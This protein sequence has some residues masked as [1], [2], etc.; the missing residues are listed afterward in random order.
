[1][2]LFTSA[3][4]AGNGNMVAG[5]GVLAAN[6][7][8]SMGETVSLAASGDLTAIGQVA[9][10]VGNVAL[11]GAGA[12]HAAKALQAATGPCGT[13]GG[14]TA[15]LPEG[16]FS[17]ANWRGYPAYLSRPTGPFRLLEGS[18]YDAAR[19]AA[20]RANRAMH[21]ADPAL[22]GLQIH[23]LHPLKCDVSPTDPLNKRALTPQLHAPATTWWNQLQREV[24][25]R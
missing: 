4:L 20:N 25:G 18:E 7:A 6:A 5:A 1:M 11:I 17:I 12:A 16:S 21:Q 13:A 14:A 2:S 24:D 22:K 9:T 8:K 19:A 15:A 10:V 23:E 3:D